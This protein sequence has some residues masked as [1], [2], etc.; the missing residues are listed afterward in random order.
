MIL[1][2]VNVVLTIFR[3]SKYTEVKNKAVFWI[4]LTNKMLNALMP[5]GVLSSYVI[6]SQLKRKLKRINHVKQIIFYHLCSYLCTQ[7]YN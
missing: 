1:F 2:Y 4:N 7:I 3:P 6:N 5:I